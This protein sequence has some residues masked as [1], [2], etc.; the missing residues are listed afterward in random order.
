MSTRRTRLAWALPLGLGPAVVAGSTFS[1]PE[2]TISL[3]YVGALLP[4]TL[5]LG[6]H[7][8]T[9]ETPKTGR[10]P[11]RLWLFTSVLLVL[12]IGVG[13]AFTRFDQALLWDLRG[14][15]QLG[16]VAASMAVVWLVAEGVAYFGGFER[17]RGLVP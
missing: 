7:V 10:S 4:L 12:L 8:A 5:V 15:Y 16:A 6:Y 13:A 1:P 2:T 9:M 11:G 14:D 17:I 3:T